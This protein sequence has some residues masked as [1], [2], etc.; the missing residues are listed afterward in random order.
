MISN[1]TRRVKRLTQEV[2]ILNKRID[3]IIAAGTPSGE[4]VMLEDDNNRVKDEMG[5]KDNG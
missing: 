1:L 2:G 3:D 4:G 5:E